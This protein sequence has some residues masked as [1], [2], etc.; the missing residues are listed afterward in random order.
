MTVL[1]QLKRPDGTL[2]ASFPWEDNKSIAQIAKSHD[3]DF[4]TSCGIG[5]CGICKCKIIAGQEYIQIDKISPPMRSLER[6]DTGKF[7]EFFAC[8]GWIT[9]EAIKDDVVHEIILE[10]NM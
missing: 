6:D 2:I 3:I 7:K 10:K 4:P 1:I 5:M 9:T 8:I